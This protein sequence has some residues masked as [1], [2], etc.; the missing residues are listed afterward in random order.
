[1]LALVPSP[2][3]HSHSSAEV[4]YGVKEMVSPALGAAGEYVK[5]TSSLLQAIRRVVSR[6]IEMRCSCFIVRVLEYLE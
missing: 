4:P 5:S 6:M 2:K 1:M 3:S